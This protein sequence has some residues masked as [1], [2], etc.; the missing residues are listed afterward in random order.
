MIA[1]WDFQTTTTGGTAAAASP[2]TPKVYSANFGLG[3]IY[4]D[5]SN[6]SSNWFVPVSGSTGTELNAFG[7]SS[8]NAGPGFSCHHRASSLALVGGTAMA[9]NGKFAIFSF[10]MTGFINLSVS[11]ASQRTSSGFTSH[12]WE[13]STDGINWNPL[14]T[15]STIPASF[16]V[17]TLPTT[18]GLNGATTAFLRLTVNGATASTGSNNRLDNIQLNATPGVTFNTDPV[19]GSPFCISDDNSASVNVSFF[20]AGTPNPANIYTAELSSSTGSFASPVAIGSLASIAST[21]TISA[22]IPAGTISGT[23]YRIRVTSS[24]PVATA[25]DNGTDLIIDKV[26]A[27][28]SNNSP[29]CAGLSLQL[30]S[31]G[32]TTYSWTGPNGFASGVQNPT[33]PVT[34]NADSGEF[35]A[36]AISTL[37]CTDTASTLA[38]VQTCSC[39]PP[40]I[41]SNST[42]PVCN[43]GANGILIS[44]FHGGVSPYTFT[45]STGAITEDVTGLTAGIYSVIVSDA[46]S[47]TDIPFL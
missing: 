3:S 25:S 4:F 22:T 24:D 19:T 21:G 44:L 8:I 5:G 20:Y 2:A 37:G 13:Y 18:S 43:G 45:W 28:A 17:I 30:F 33:I 42:M 9:A 16:G 46:I 6:N 34:V 29:V 12:V 26:V 39:I 38:I 10:S 40:T 11:Y 23:G 36:T 47:C 31:G 35:I 15:V 32:G 1:G 14:T 7:G 27:T 41:T